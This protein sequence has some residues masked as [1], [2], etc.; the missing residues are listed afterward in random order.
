MEASMIMNNNLAI[1][2]IGFDGYDDLWDDFFTLF[3]KYWENC[4]YS[5]YLA[6]N[7]KK[8]NFSNV[9]VINAGANAEWSRKVQVALDTIEEEYICLLLEDFY[10]GYPICQEEIDKLMHLI[11]SDK[12]IYYKLKTYFPIKTKKYKGYNFLS[13]IP[14]NLKY[15]ISL[16]PAIWQRDFLKEK[17][18]KENYNAWKFE[19]DRVREE[20]GGTDAPIEGCVYD[21]RN[22]LQI[23]HGVV[24]GKYLPQTVKFF[25]KQGYCLNMEHRQVMRGK[26][27]I[28]YKLKEIKW[29]KPIRT[30]LKK[31]LNILGVKFVS[32]ING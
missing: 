8:Y 20:A 19:V 4:P 31:I 22:I 1:L 16:Q 15:G 17:V 6:N 29:P 23:Q 28:I 5:V 21:N 24:Q 10:V 30:L 13:V 27:Y 9:K 14:E 7:E 3:F 11:S 26:Q 32:D 25:K 12:L 18:G 2:V